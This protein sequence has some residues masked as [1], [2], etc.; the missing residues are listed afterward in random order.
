MTVAITRHMLTIPKTGRRVHYRCCGNGPALLMIHQ[1]PR[2][3]A[4]YEALMRQWGEHFTCIVPDTPGFGQSD[5]LPQVNGDDPEIN[6]FAD[7]LCEFLDAMGIARCPAY[8]FHS[9]GIILVTAVKRHPE[10]FECLAIGGYGI[11][12]DEEMQI[13]GERY[14]PEFHPSGFG[15]HL[16]WLWNRILEQSWVFPWFDTR[17]KARLPGPHTK[18]AKINQS[19]LDMLNAGNHYRAG[20]GAV[21]RAPR[22]IPDTN[23][24]VPPC[25]ITAYDGDPLQ[26]HIDRLGDMPDGWSAKKVKTEAD[27]E[28]VSLA[29]LI[30]Q[31]DA[32]ATTVRLVEDTNQGWLAL[33]EGLIHWKGERGGKLILHA[34]AS[35]MR[36]PGP[37]EI[38]IDL[39]GHGQSDQFSDLES[40]IEAIATALDATEVIWPNPP[41]GD[42]ALLYPDLEPD[43]FGQY[44]QRAWAV[45]RAEVF[46]EP[47]Y[48]VNDLHTIPIDSAKLAPHSLQSRTNARLRAGSNAR[49]WHEFLLSRNGAPT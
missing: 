49:R 46:F 23:A 17:E 5:P 6:D 37:G 8:G 12:T 48:E 42:P 35:E 36:E 47:W 34:P 20:Y 39:P 21:L 41:A 45:A 26:E 27:H 15:E 11:W 1:S 38:T 30:E 22:D 9:G 44:L 10:R 19:V 3:S 24:K 29:F 7:A 4:E 32:S 18:L 14:L 16:A 13:F 43:R 2:S 40:V 25:L 31:Y 28:S 33:K